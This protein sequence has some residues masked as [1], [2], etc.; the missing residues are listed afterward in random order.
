MKDLLT[1]LE[2]RS[3]AESI[4]FLCA[5]FCKKFLYNKPSALMKLFCIYF[6]F[7]STSTLFLF[8][9]PLYL[10]RKCF[11]TEHKISCLSER[12]DLSVNYIDPFAPW[13]HSYVTE[14]IIYPKTT[15]LQQLFAWQRFFCIFYCVDDLVGRSGFNPYSLF[16]LYP[17]VVFFI[18]S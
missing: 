12:L 9:K 1:C 13:F 18:L 16:I 10:L 15:L 2:S 3:I 17:I 4:P 8:S 6:M 11:R 5:E 7:I 14:S